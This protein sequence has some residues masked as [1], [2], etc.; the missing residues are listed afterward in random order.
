MALRLDL[1]L[2]AWHVCMKMRDLPRSFVV[3]DLVGTFVAVCTFLDSSIRSKEIRNRPGKKP[4]RQ[5]VYT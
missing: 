2:I 4:H 1:N 5:Q 3:D